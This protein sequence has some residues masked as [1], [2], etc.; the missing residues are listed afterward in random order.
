[1]RRMNQS[2]P[3][4]Y[5]HAGGDARE[6]TAPALALPLKHVSFASAVPATSLPFPYSSCDR[7]VV[8]AMFLA[9]ERN[10][11]DERCFVPS[12]RS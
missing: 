1:M 7:C 12:E 2:L 6:G 8:R 4:P 10:E 11:F 3:H 5:C 9:D